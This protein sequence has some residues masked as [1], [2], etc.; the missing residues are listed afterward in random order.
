[1]SYFENFPIINYR[2]PTTG[3][4][5]TVTDILKRVGIKKSLYCHPDCHYSSIMVNSMAS[6]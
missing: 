4:M 1:M 3:V 6:D 5:R 2:D